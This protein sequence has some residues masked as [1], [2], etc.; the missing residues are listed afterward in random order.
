PAYGQRTQTGCGLLRSR[1]GGQAW[2]PPQS[3]R[4][5]GLEKGGKRLSVFTPI[6]RA[7]PEDG[8]I[9]RSSEIA[10]SYIGRRVPNC[11]LLQPPCKVAALFSRTTP[12]LATKSI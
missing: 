6:G 3:R 12:W 4:R 11:P 9:A 7:L 5:P 2:A 1:H 10:G 8:W